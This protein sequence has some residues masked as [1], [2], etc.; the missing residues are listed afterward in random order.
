[1][2]EKFPHRVE[3]PWGYE[4]ILAHTPKYAG[5]L[6]FVKKGHRLS[7]QYHR[8]K[9]ESFYVHEGKAIIEMD[10]HDGEMIEIIIETGCCIRIR[11]MIR[12]RLKALEDTTL[13]EFSTPELDDIERLSDDYGR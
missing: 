10:G 11:P 7:L 4:L 12:H 5:K 9:D 3:K 8:Q 13:F 6:I 2:G 1:M